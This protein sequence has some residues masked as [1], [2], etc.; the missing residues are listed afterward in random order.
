MGL[1]AFIRKLPKDIVVQ[2]DQQGEYLKEIRGFYWP[3][4]ELL[5]WRNHRKLNMWMLTRA[6]DRYHIAPSEVLSGREIRL[7]EEDLLA[8]KLEMVFGDMFKTYWASSGA[9]AMVDIDAQIID[10]LIRVVRRGKS[11]VFYTSSW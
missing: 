11:I 7:D 4:N 5:Y 2:A 10:H 8:L 9:E 1:D 3:K 6:L